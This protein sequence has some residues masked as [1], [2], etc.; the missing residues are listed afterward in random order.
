MHVDHAVEQR[1]VHGAD[2]G[3][4]VGAVAGT[5]H[6]RAGRQVVLADAA[7]VNQRL[8]G[9]LNLVGAWVQLVQKQ[10]EGLGAGDHARRA[11][12]AGAVDDLGH[13]D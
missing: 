8:E 7:L 3:A 5:D 4:V 9:L 12:A 10:A 2:D 1:R 13:T 11:E 6:N